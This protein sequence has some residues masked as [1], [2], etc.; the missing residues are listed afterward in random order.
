MQEPVRQ[1]QIGIVPRDAGLLG[2]REEAPALSLDELDALFDRHISEILAAFAGHDAFDL[3]GALGLINV[4]VNLE[5]PD[6]YAGPGLIAAAELGATISACAARAR[7]AQSLDDGEGSRRS[8][9]ETAYSVQD[10]LIASV[11]ISGP[12]DED[13]ATTDTV[14]HRFFSQTRTIRNERFDHQ[15]DELL[16]GLFGLP[17]ISARCRAALGFDAQEAFVIWDAIAARF[18]T[19]YKSAFTGDEDPTPGIGGALAMRAEHLVE[20]AGLPES[21]VAGFIDTFSVSLGEVPV[22]QRTDDGMLIR[23]RPL[24]RDG[25]RF[26]CTVPSN[27]LRAIRPA[28]EAALKPTSGWEAY[29]RHRGGYCESRVVG[30]L[31]DFLRPDVSLSKLS[32]EVPSAVGECDA[33]L[34]IDDTAVIVE[35]KSGALRVAGDPSRPERLGW[36]VRD[37]IQRPAGQLDGARA[38]LLA[39]AQMRDPSGPIVVPSGHIR[40]VFGV[41][42]TLEPLAFA[43]PM[44]WQLQDESLLS[45]GPTLPWVIGLHELESICMML[46][47]PCQLLHFLDAHQRMDQLRCVVATDEI[48]VFMAYLDMGLRFGWLPDAERILLPP[49]SDQLNNWVFY[50]RGL[51]ATVTARPKQYFPI[52]TRLA[53]RAE[54]RR[55]DRDR[56]GGF[57]SS[58]F[59]VI[60]SALD[61]ADI[62]RLGHPVSH[63]I[64]RCNE[65]AR[66]GR[67]GVRRWRH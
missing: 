42:V 2:S 52:P 38:A 65:P 36:T 37:M 11:L 51:R 59:E 60:E 7:T 16:M 56:P 21:V 31:S 47:F 63:A 54:L 58:S 43:A 62:E 9:F 24:V 20:D 34:L 40:R 41:I 28:L 35:V 25:D 48:D 50:K 57:V 64:A 39:G 33:V 8:P 45:A 17:W 49:D 29:Q 55:L 4:A 32:F 44:L 10:R 19:F 30:I 61:D 18:E 15:E 46:E 27:L 6:E 1:G 12:G 3:I 23:C 26:I 14:Y 53:T 67:P 5:R 66:R 22:P 13:H